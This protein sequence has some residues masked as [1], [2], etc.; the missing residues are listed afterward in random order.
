LPRS[1]RPGTRGKLPLAE[2]VDEQF[3]AVLRL[4]G[5]ELVL[6]TVLYARVSA[7]VNRVLTAAADR[8]DTPTDARELQVRWDRIIV[9]R[10]TLQGVAVLAL[11][12]T[13]V[14]S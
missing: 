8:H 12:L 14:L 2:L 3:E 11:G 7:P 10:A 1:R 5:A 9:L 13:L 4:V 6:W